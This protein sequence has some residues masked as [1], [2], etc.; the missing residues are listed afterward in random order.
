MR[1]LLQLGSSRARAWFNDLVMGCDVSRI[2]TEYDDLVCTRKVQA[3]TS[4]KSRDEKDEDVRVLMKLVDHRHTICLFGGPIKLD[5]SQIC[6]FMNCLVN[7]EEVNVLF[8]R[9]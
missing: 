5:I 2:R 3:S 9:R 4:G 8:D 6:S 7:S 1:Y